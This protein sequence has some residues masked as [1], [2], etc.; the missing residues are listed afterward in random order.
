[1]KEVV[2][3]GAT[4]IL[5]RYGDRYYAAIGRCYHLGG[6]LATGKL[7]GTVITCPLHDSQFDLGDGR[8]IRWLK[9]TGLL[10]KVGKAIKSPK[11][12][13]TYAVKID[14]DRIMVSL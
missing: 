12:L 4:I 2:I 13:K 6:R 1:M 7:Q 10:S 5:A 3:E 11:P 9:G 14:G 8:V